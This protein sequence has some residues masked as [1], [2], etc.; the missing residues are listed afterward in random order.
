VLKESEAVKAIIERARAALWCLVK[1]R[2]GFED[3][4]TNHPQPVET[5]IKAIYFCLQERYNIE[6]GRE[7]RYYA[8]EW[9]VVR[10]PHEVIRGLEATCID[11]ALLLA[12]CLENRHLNPVIIIVRTGIDADGYEI[13]HALISCWLDK[14]QMIRPIGRNGHRVKQ[15]VEQGQLLL[16]NSVGFAHGQEADELFGECQ[17]K[18]KEYLDKACARQDD[19]DFVYALDICAARYAGIEPMPFGR[20]I[21]FDHLA[22]L[23]MSRARR[24]AEELQSKN[25]GARHLLLGLLSRGNGRLS[26]AIAGLGKDAKEMA[27][28]ARESI[29]RATTPRPFLLENDDWRAVLRRAKDIARQM[30]VMLVTEDDLA[31]ALLKTQSKLDEV[32]AKVNLTRDQCLLELEKLLRASPLAS[33]WRSSE[34][35]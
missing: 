25:I 18:G 23:A 11:L 29:R 31:I 4:L 21:Q 20:G 1:G 19:H 33:E 26:Q 27:R 22:W 17:A 28:I 24:E 34:G 6:Y 7:P 14:P 3:V 32:F 5:I 12:A 9:Q 35:V 16:L 10:F 15:W 8:A 13:H 2:P 30:D